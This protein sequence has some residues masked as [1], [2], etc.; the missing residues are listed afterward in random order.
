MLGFLYMGLW[1]GEISGERFLAGIPHST[2]ADNPPP[3]PLGIPWHGPGMAQTPGGP[4]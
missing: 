2:G 3:T 4:D 1:G